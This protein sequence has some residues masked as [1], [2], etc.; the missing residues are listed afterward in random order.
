MVRYTVT[1]QL[2]PLV[3]RVNAVRWLESTLEALCI[4]YDGQLGAEA[5]GPAGVNN[6]TFDV[7]LPGAVQIEDFRRAV[8][9]GLVSHEGYDVLVLAPA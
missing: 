1:I 4:A 6:V 9:Q 2:P 3:N 7:Q 5:V 8:V